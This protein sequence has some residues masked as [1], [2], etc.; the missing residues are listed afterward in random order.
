MDWQK[1]DEEYWSKKI[2][3]YFHDPIDK[4]FKI[5]G[6]ENRARKIVEKIIGYET[7]K[8]DDFWK[9]ADGVAAG[10]ERGFVPSYNKDEQKNGSIDF[11][12]N[13]IITHPT[14]AKLKDKKEAHLHID[15]NKIKL[16]EL[17][18]EYSIIIDKLFSFS[19]KQEIK[20]DKERSYKNKFLSFLLAHIALRFQLAENESTLGAFWHR[21]PADSRFPDHSIWQHNALVSSINSS[22]KNELNCSNVGI[23]VFS[24]SPVQS[25]ISKARKLRDFWTGSVLLSYLAFEGIVWI[26]E[27][28]GCDHILYPSI[29]DQP[30]VL[31]YVEEKYFEYTNQRLNGNSGI[32]RL[33]RDQSIASFPNKFVSLIPF[34]KADIIANEIETAIQQKWMQLSKISGNDLQNKLN[35]KE[36]E[37][38]FVENLFERQFKN[39]W[40]FNWA[41]NVL[42]D[43]RDK[44]VLECFIQKKQCKNVFN[45]YEQLKKFPK[46]EE[47]K[48]NN[49]GILY[50]LSHSLVQT[51]LAASKSKKIVK[52]EKENGEKCSLCG[53]F[54]VINTYNSE[55]KS[56]AKDYTSNLKQTWEN[57]VNKYCQNDFKQ[58][59]K[60]CSICFLK[61]VAP[62]IFKQNRDPHLSWILGEYESFPS[63]SYIALYEYFK[64][65]NIVSH[66][67]K[68]KLAQI[69]FDKN[70]TDSEYKKA[71]IKNS[72]ENKDKNIKES[73]KYYALLVMDGDK[74]GSLINGETIGSTW[75]S[76]MHPDIKNRLL[77]KDFDKN[78]SIPWQ[79]I[80]KD[81]NMSKRLITPAIHASISE[82]LSDFSIYDVSNIINKYEGRLIY[83]GGDD[84]FA[85][86]PVSNLLSAIK[87][88]RK[89]Y[90]F[91]FRF[92]SS[93]ENLCN[94]EYFRDLIDN[95]D[96]KYKPQKGKLSV[97]LGQYKDISIS[98]G[99]L[100]CHHKENLADMIELTHSILDKA[101]ENEN[102]NA[103]GIALKKRSGGTREYFVRWDEK[104]DENDEDNFLYDLFENFSRF[105]DKE[106]SK[107]FGY[108]L[109]ELENGI[110]SILNINKADDN[111]INKM[112][113]DYIGSILVKSGKLVESIKEEEKIRQISKDI[114]SL[115]LRK[116]NYKYKDNTNNT[117]LTLN[118]DPLIISG[119]L[120]EKSC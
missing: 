7:S 94:E 60:L 22:M 111:N 70:E 68:I 100:I 16:D 8:G 89:C 55:S 84:I 118:I 102:R 6:H 14:S 51:T 99:A 88:I 73:D 27:N 49:I 50:S 95:K 69:F 86:L 44:N 24:I 107:Y 79:D 63:T 110:K 72:E 5:Q 47:Y 65:N 31:K 109:E 3:A 101:K 62:I 85:I 54:E 20:D 17:F 57:I 116:K 74:M 117:R 78:Y 21:I 48:E 26:I 119:F 32:S 80:F 41:A 28:L 114:R 29:V 9:I 1:P 106:L 13:P 35:L 2:I 45:F 15:L 40:D 66:D 113:E 71:F 12:N 58:N 108:H 87:E 53:E 93:D 81:E 92:I 52:R 18:D 90:S 75:E 38:I 4:V 56:I 115:I 105:F 64:R 23:L 120:H 67:E 43:V 83:A 77:N 19:I 30:L 76:I 11:N 91:L 36:N 103:V 82:A 59:E 34:D 25:F 98:A 112:A 46:F 33:R 61:R 97:H 37:K 96:Q 42:F 10:F 104:T 39:Y